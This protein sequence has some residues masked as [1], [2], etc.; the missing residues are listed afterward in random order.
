MVIKAGRSLPFSQRGLSIGSLVVKSYV[1]LVG[2]RVRFPAGAA[3]NIFFPAGLGSLFVFRLIDP[4]LWHPSSPV[5]IWCPVCCAG[6][7]GKGP[8]LLE[9]EGSS[10]V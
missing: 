3:R 10:A 5:L 8:R 7:L 2:P 4:G 9:E 6:A 1:A